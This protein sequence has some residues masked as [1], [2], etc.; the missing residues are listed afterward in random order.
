MMLTLI[1]NHISVAKE[2]PLVWTSWLSLVAFEDLP[3]FSTLK[4]IPPEHIIQSLLYRLRQYGEN[5]DVK[6][7]QQN[8]EVRYG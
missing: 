2:M 7:Q 6:T 3:E 8:V 4:S 1:Q 5:T